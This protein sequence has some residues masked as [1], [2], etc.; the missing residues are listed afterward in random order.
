M[1]AS[2]D[3]LPHSCESFLEEFPLLRRLTNPGVLLRLRFGLGTVVRLD[4][5]D[6]FDVL[7][8]PYVIYE[9]TRRRSHPGSVP[10]DNPDCFSREDRALD[11][12]N[13]IPPSTLMRAF[14]ETRLPVCSAVMP[15]PVS[16]TATVIHLR[17]FS[18][19]WRGRW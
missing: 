8:A 15:M 9:L 17:P 14:Q 4:S 7:G 16:A 2:P 18:C 11:R 10:L 12:E 13:E 19:P 5:A 3:N 6:G 1:T